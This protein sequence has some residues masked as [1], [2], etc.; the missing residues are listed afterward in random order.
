M[1]VLHPNAV[2]K[3]FATCVCVKGFIMDLWSERQ[4]I[5]ESTNLVEHFV[6]VYCYGILFIPVI[7]GIKCFID[8]LSHSFFT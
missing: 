5:T 2:L 1:S 4:F 7:E 8:W 3:Y 6:S